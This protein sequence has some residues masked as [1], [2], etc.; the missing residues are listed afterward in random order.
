MP[1]KFVTP[2]LWSSNIKEIDLQADKKRIILNVLNFGTK[3]ATDWLFSFYSRSEIKSVIV[4]QGAKGELSNKSLNYWSLILNI[5]S[6]HLVRA[7]L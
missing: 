5:N 7:R 3:Q 6:E 2:Y 1:P 4:S